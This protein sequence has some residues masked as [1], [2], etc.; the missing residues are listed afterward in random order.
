MEKRFALGKGLSALIPDADLVG[1][2]PEGFVRIHRSRL[3]NWRRVR[4]FIADPDHESVVVLLSGQRLE[5]S[6]AHLK[7]LQRRLL[8]DR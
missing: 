1:L 4:E 6:P 3:V 7:E 2:K 8:E 5:A